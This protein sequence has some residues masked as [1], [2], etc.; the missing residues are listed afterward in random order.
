MLVGA[1]AAGVG[2]LSIAIVIPLWYFATKHTSI[3]SIT[4]I[5]GLFGA[6]LAVLGYKIVKM[7][8]KRQ[9]IIKTAIRLVRYLLSAV[10]LY[11]TALFYARGILIAAIPLTFALFIAMSVFIYG[12]KTAF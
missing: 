12:K 2:I 10:V 8:Q 7:P 5:G 9:I 6:W 3:Y 11:F 1:T 4:V